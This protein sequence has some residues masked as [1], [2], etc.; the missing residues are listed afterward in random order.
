MEVTGYKYTNEQ[1]AINAREQVDAYYGIPV[2][3]DD[4]TQNWVDYNTATLDNPIF[5]YIIFDESLRVVLGEP[6]TF[7]VTT[8]FE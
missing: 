4:V 6:S 5:Y 2:S 7:E 1:D 3:P 8:P